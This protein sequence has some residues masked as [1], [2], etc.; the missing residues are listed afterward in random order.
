MFTFVAFYVYFGLLVVQWVANVPADPGAR[1][2]TLRPRRAG[3][4]GAGED[5]RTPLLIAN[6]K[7]HR[8][9]G[10]I[11]QPQDQQVRSRVRVCACV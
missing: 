9:H 5:E 11:E 1:R 6:G 7:V 4:P 3:A 8:K 10:A 2:A